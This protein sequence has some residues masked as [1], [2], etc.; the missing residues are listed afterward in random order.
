MRNS[1]VPCWTNPGRQAPST[2]TG[3]RTLNDL[4]PSRSLSEQACLRYPRGTRVRQDLGFDGYQPRVARLDPPKKN[5]ESRVGSRPC[6]S[7]T[8]ACRRKAQAYGQRGLTPH[9][10]RYLRPCH[11]SGLPLAEFA[12][13]P[14]WA[15]VENLTEILIPDKVYCAKRDSQRPRD[16]PVVRPC[17]R[18]RLS[19]RSQDCQSRGDLGSE[20]H[21]IAACG[22][23]GEC[24]H[25]RARGGM[26]AFVLTRITK[27]TSVIPIRDHQAQHPSWHR[28]S[29]TIGA[30][31]RGA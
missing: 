12:R 23:L 13:Q 1:T 21:M 31:N 14:W 17:K 15:S 9:P 2:E 10:G 28:C 8:G 24:F 3:R 20:E 26:P 18:R 19:T 5:R 29:E 4:I 16:G 6:R 11:G 30:R 22:L 7:R 27:V 25:H